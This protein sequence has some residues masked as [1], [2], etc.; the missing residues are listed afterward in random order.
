MEEGRLKHEAKDQNKVKLIL[1]DNTKYP[2]EGT[3]QFRDVTVDPTT[4]SVVLRAIFP[5]PENV[6]LPGMF[7]RAIVKEGIN[8]KAIMVPQQTVF[9][10]TK[11][12]PFVYIVDKESKVQ[13]R[14]IIIDR[15]I[16]DKW[17]VSEGLSAGEQVIMEGVQKVMPGMPVKTVPYVT[18]QKPERPGS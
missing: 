3:L 4:G 1:E 18:Q 8:K 15:A 6:L 12:N 11:G 13:I 9:R 2:L 17:L 16:E 5:N 14:P 7:V 10:D